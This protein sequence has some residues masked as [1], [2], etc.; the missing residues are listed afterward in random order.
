MLCLIIWLQIY[1]KRSQFQRKTG[2]FLDVATNKRL[3]IFSKTQSKV[4]E[5][6]QQGTDGVIAH[7]DIDN[8]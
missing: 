5:G 3:Y 2:A 1:S 7:W 8:S 4:Q 6:A